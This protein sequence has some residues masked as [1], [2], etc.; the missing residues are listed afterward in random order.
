MQSALAACCSTGLEC[1]LHHN[2]YSK[3]VRRASDVHLFAT[4]IGTTSLSAARDWLMQNVLQSTDEYSR[5]LATNMTQLVQSNFQIDDCI[6]KAWFINPGNCWNVQML[7]TIQAQRALL[8]SDKMILFAIVTLNNGGGNILRC[9]L[10][11]LVPS[12]SAS[13]PLLTVDIEREG[14]SERTSMF[15][16]LPPLDG[17]FYDLENATTTTAAVLGTRLTDQGTFVGSKGVERT[18]QEISNSRVECSLGTGQA[19]SILR[20]A[21]EYTQTHTHTHT[22]TY[23]H[24]HTH[25]I[26]VI[27]LR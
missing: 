3:V 4:G 12:P 22:H 11:S 16:K 26:T 24:T 21:D 23:I 10:L 27:S 7:P 17:S 18:V 8:L 6:N 20:A 5:K 9:H 1:V 19:H 2:I 13:D 15:N 14:D 25:I